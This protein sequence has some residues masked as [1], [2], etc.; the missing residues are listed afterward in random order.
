MTALRRLI[1]A[2]H[3][4]IILGIGNVA[5]LI[6]RLCI[7]HWDIMS[8]TYGQT[9]TLLCCFKIASMK[10]IQSKPNSMRFSLLSLYTA[11]ASHYQA[12]NLNPIDKIYFKQSSSNA[13]QLII[14]CYSLIQWHNLSI[15]STSML[16]YSLKLYKYALSVQSFLHAECPYAVIA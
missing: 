16:I 6:W 2:E 4:F 7:P 15:L 11:L 13:Y 1:K 3:W 10:V 14:L 8:D 5:A 9:C 12:P